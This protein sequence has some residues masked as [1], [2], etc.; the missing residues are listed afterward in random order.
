VSEPDYLVV[1]LA[2]GPDWDRAKPRREQLG[3]D[4]HAAFMD[5]LVDDGFILLGGPVGDSEGEHTMHVVT[6]TDEQAVRE[7]LAQDP[8]AGDLLT[9]ASIEPWHTWLRAPAP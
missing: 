7:R 4:A 6:E 5:S 3:W 9:V 1:T 2:K 8:W